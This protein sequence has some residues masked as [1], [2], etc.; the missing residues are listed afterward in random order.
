MFR[1][2]G[3]FGPL[4]GSLGG[5][6]G[7]QQIPAGGVG[8]E[9][10]QMN[11][12]GDMLM[13]MAG[14]LLAGSGYSPQRRGLGELMGQALLAGQQAKAQ[15]M[16]FNAQQ[17]EAAQMAKLRDA[18]IK[19]LENSSQN[20]PTSVREYEFAK[21]NGFQGSFQDWIASG[22]AQ[23]LPADLQV[24][25][26]YKSATPEERAMFD[27]LNGRQQA[28][29]YQ[30]VQRVLPDGSTQQ[31]TF[32]A[33]SGQTSWDESVVP[34]GMKPMV[35]A[36][37]A[38]IGGAQGDQASK[39]PAKAS[40]EYVLSEMEKQLPETTQGGIGG[41]VGKVGS[42]F[43]HKDAQRFDNLR[44]QLSTELRTVF[45]IP[46]EGTLSDREQAQYGVQL[47]SRDNHP[48]VNQKILNDLRQRTKL[49]TETPMGPWRDASTPQQSGGWKVEVVE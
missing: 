43:D 17:S 4:T 22:N 26:W 40:M 18:Q 28:P 35:D 13:A 47:P 19:N 33:R 24:M 45:R 30:W 46:G 25:E 6:F 34:A 44:E 5:I 41:V 36:R 14:Q 2:P 21:Q 29:Y 11:P 32:N 49:R 20:D 8:G 7:S 9:P 10:Q 16:Q 38:A 42:V 27:K 31:G 3:I 1:T 23:S 15:S 12:K 37:G 48:S 39:A